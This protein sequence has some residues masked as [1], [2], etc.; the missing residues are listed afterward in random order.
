MGFIVAFD[1]DRW[2]T[3]YPE[4]VA[5]QQATAELYFQEAGMY[6]RNDGFSPCRTADIQSLILDM[7][8]AHVA[9]L[10][11]QSQGSETPGAPQDAN[12]PVGRLTSATQGS[13]TVQY[14]AGIPPSEQSAF[15]MQTKYGFGFWR[16]TAAYRTMRYM[17]GALQP[18]GLPGMTWPYVIPVRRI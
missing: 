11:S 14:D 15:F 1:Y 4:F 2:V 18:G 9:A 17:P 10:Y 8:T 16:A 5:V 7:L 12:S 13:V 6:W 3:R